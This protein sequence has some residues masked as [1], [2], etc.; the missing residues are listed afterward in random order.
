MVPAE[1]PAKIS[2]RI[3]KI[4]VTLKKRY[5]EPTEKDVRYGQS[6]MA[7]KLPECLSGGEAHFFYEW[8]WP[9]RKKLVLSLGQREL[10]P[11]EVPKNATAAQT[12]HIRYEDGR[13]PKRAAGAAADMTRVVLMR[14]GLVLDAREGALPRMITPI[15]FFV[16]G[17]IGSGRQYVSWIHLEDW[18]AL[19]R[20]AFEEARVAGPVNATTS[21]P[22][23]NAEFTRATAAELHRPALMRVPAFAVRALVGEMGDALVVGGQRVV[24]K[25][26]LDL[27]F[28]FRF[29]DLRP[30][31]ADVL[32]R[33]VRKSESPRVR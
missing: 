20:W 13:S 21:Q 6:C 29:P 17:A 25:R 3:E 18:V 12:I 7:D 19:V 30:A 32:G 24:P 8:R 5:G 15:K 33:N 4:V 11:G 16:G 10:A 14:S 27:G 22:V 26:A 31:L 1:E 9:A 2:T 28:R 23:D